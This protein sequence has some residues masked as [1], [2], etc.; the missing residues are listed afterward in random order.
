MNGF[1]LLDHKWKCLKW[2]LGLSWGWGCDF[3][4]HLTLAWLIEIHSHY[5]YGSIDSV[6]VH[7]CPIPTE[8]SFW[9]WMLPFRFRF[10]SKSMCSYGKHSCEHG[11]LALQYRS[12]YSRAMTMRLRGID[13]G[14]SIKFMVVLRVNISLATMSTA[15]MEWMLF[16]AFVVF[17]M[18]INLRQ[19]HS[20]IAMCVYRWLQVNEWLWNTLLADVVQLL[21]DAQKR[22][23]K[24]YQS[25]KNKKSHAERNSSHLLATIENSSLE[26]DYPMLVSIPESFIDE[27]RSS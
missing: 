16:I 25:A 5:G 13:E 18:R 4:F 15:V 24:Q 3:H 11:P 1:A 10:F 7:S 27:H 8:N 6:L 14:K 20:L 2:K 17:R 9:E 19:N 26:E 12:L 22:S 23:S 21:F